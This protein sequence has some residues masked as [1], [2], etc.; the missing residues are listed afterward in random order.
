MT[1]EGI[2]YRKHRQ[3][4]CATS[5]KRHWIRIKLWHNNSR[6]SFRW[7]LSS[8]HVRLLYI[9]HNQQP[10]QFFLFSTVP[11]RYNKLWWSPI[12]CSPHSLTH[13]VLLL[14]YSAMCKNTIYGGGAVMDGW[15]LGLTDGCSAC[16]RILYNCAWMAI[17]KP[18]DDRK[19]ICAIIQRSLRT[20]NT[21]HTYDK[22][23]GRSIA[24]WRSKVIVY[25]IIFY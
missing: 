4:N 5:Y 24:T 21:R 17:V 3:L 2:Y 11:I 10:L 15:V 25:P 16:T 19:L 13:W 8:Q 9:L 12:K 22:C 23:G 18:T 6:S 7:H 14:F 1:S 20:T